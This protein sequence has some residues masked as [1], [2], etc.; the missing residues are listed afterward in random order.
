MTC[1]RFRSVLLSFAILSICA[2]TGTAQ[3]M[4]VSERLDTT[5]PTQ[6]NNPRSPATLTPPSFLHLLI[7]RNVDVQFSKLGSDVN[8][9]LSEGEA[10][11]YETTFFMG[12]RN[13][14]R[15]RQ[16]TP[17]ERLQNLTTANTSLL[18]ESVKNNELGI[19]NKLP[20][21]A[22]VSLSYKAVGK[23]NNLI[24]QTSPP[25]DT[26][27]NSSLNLLL[28]QPLLRNAGRSTTETDRRI[29][30][31]EYQ[32]SLQQLAQQTSKTSM[33]GLTLYWQLFRA[34]ETRQLRTQALAHT[35]D[36]LKD[37]QAR[38]NA[39]KLA[40][41]A[42]LELQGTLLSRK[43]ELSRSQQAYYEA[44][45]KVLSTLNFAS[46]NSAT[47]ALKVP[48]SEP[49]ALRLPASPPS[50][51][52]LQLWA[53]YQIAQLKQQQAQTRFNFA[54]N[55]TK[56][57]VDLILGYSSTG[58]SNLP[59][60]AR[61]YAA[62]GSY[63]DW[64]MGINFEIPLGG[65]QKA[66]NQMLAQRTRLQQAE[67]EIEAIRIA[68]TNDLLVRKT[69]LQNALHITDLSLKEIDLRKTLVDNEQRRIDLGTGSLGTLTQKRADL[70]EAQQRLIEN[71]VRYEIALAAW[72]Y[73]QGTL[74]SD[75]G[76]VVTR[77]AA[78]PT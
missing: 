49:G 25:Y 69:D 29:A 44:H 20:S 11:L 61:S 39:G 74:L 17:D 9:H 72:Q 23:A 28:K 6:P 24:P 46:D 62:H 3:D 2:R 71:R 37:T 53:P 41:T 15:N 48:L 19:R 32:V 22:E 51:A 7:E 27:Y 5:E 1:W 73:A 40:S 31:L 13:E 52:A 35:Q 56:P 36:L 55:Q 66:K 63:P 33:D 14:R 50:E 75:H 38:V 57:M 12:L 18:D 8:R 10:S 76:I 64:Y 68:F 67:L 59:Q 65:N 78:S 42:V 60:D 45:S 34:Q 26:E 21:G 30:E 43:A 54:Q 77:D 47:I 58:Y 70:V 4:A 16:R